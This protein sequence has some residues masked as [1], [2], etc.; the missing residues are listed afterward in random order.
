MS[1]NKTLAIIV[2][3]ILSAIT[4]SNIFG[5]KSTPS[6]FWDSEQTKQKK[7]SEKTKQLMYQ[8]KIDSTNNYH[9]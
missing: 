7:T 5:D 4:L 3:A 8:F 6:D 2:I 9:K 1:Y